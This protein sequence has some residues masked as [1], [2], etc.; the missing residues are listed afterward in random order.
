MM[1]NDTAH[2]LLMETRMRLL[3]QRINRLQQIGW[4]EQETRKAA[5]P[6]RSVLDILMGFSETLWR[7]V[8]ASRTGAEPVPSKLR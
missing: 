4:F 8:M 5:R 2:A 7:V 1:V 6:R 3:E